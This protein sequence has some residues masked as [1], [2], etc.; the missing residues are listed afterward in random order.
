MSQ[1][2]CTP[3]KLTFLPLSIENPLNISTKEVKFVSEELTQYRHH[4]ISAKE[5]G[6]AL[7]QDVQR[8]QE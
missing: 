6:K 8:W 2:P 1:G 3:V 5:I 4:I 7:L